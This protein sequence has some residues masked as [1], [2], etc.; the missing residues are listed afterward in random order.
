[1]QASNDL[2][3]QVSL[4]LGASVL[5]VI[6]IITLIIMIILFFIYGRN[7]RVIPTAE[8]FNQDKRYRVEKN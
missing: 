8:E 7:V 2:G 4:W 3:G 1:M 6:E 5:S